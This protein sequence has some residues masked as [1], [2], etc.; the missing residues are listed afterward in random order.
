MNCPNGHEL[1]SVHELRLSAHEL[2]NFVLHYGI[3]TTMHALRAI[4]GAQA[5]IHYGFAVN[6]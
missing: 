6:S 4:H 3:I 2:Q 1:N 5:K